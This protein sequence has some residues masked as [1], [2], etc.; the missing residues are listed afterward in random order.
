MFGLKRFG[1]L[2]HPGYNGGGK[3]GGGGNT[4]GGQAQDF[5]GV[6]ARAPYANMLGNLL[7]GQP[8]TTGGTT[9]TDKRGD[10]TTV[11]QQ[12]VSLT[13]YVKSQ[14]GYQFGFDQSM[15]AL[16]RQQQ[17]TGQAGGGAQQVAL[18][19]FGADYAGKYM[20]QMIGNLM[21]AS[22]AGTA[23]MN[24][25]QQQST[26]M[27]TMAGIAGAGLGYLAS[28][29]GGGGSMFDAAASFMLA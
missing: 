2:K 15:Q 12:S 13:D 9:I 16:T 5:F 18:Q 10:Q 24:L 25:G 19:G 26:G 7:L 17:A 14:P 4:A 27:Q 20:Q 23:P 3:G 28:S 22:G 6:G 11:G 1:I 21:P 29:G 8:M